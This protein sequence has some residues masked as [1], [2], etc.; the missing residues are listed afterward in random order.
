VGIPPSPAEPAPSEVGAGGRVVEPETA[1]EREV[2]ARAASDPD[3]FAL[4][5]RR[6]VDPIYRFAYRRS[7]SR[8]VA[9]D[10]TSATFEK[11]L[12]GLD[13][14]EWRQGGIRPWLYRIAANEVTDHYRRARRDASP[15]AQRAMRLISPDPALDA[16]PSLSDV[17]VEHLRAALGSISPRYQEALSLRYLAGLSTEEAA[18]ALGCSRSTLAVVLHRAGRALRRQLGAEGG[19]TR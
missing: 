8:E 9:E 11:A 17:P 10:V 12:R 3:A 18:A 13:R 16:E 14:F 19:A 15:A 2:V 5:Y 4:L 7:G 1:D 6:Y